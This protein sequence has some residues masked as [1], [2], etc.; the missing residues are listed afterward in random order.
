MRVQISKVRA[1]LGVTQ[2]QLADWTGISRPYLAQ[3]ES[4]QRNLSAKRQQQIADV[5]GVDPTE[6]VDFS[7]P[8]PA[9][10]EKLLEAFRQ[11]SR[12]QRQEW[13]KMARII[14]GKSDEASDVD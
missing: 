5:L 1:R 4:G 10:E 6:L 12:S 9:E 2:K 13:L 11:L 14:N 7:A 3:M 8:D